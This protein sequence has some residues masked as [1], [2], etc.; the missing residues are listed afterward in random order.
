MGGT[1]M[2]APYHWQFTAAV[3][4]GSGQFVLADEINIAT[5][6]TGGALGDLDGDGDLDVFITQSANLPDVV[7]I[8]DGSGNFT[9]SG[10]ALGTTQSK[11]VGIAKLAR[12]LGAWLTSHKMVGV[13]G[14]RCA[15]H[16]NCSRPV[17]TARLRSAHPA[18]CVAATRDSPDGCRIS[19]GPRALRFSCGTGRRDRKRAR[20]IRLARGP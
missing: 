10:Q 3:G 12:W 5:A 14:G 17:R 15:R 7:F 11:A 16:R 8:N 6:G 1:P 19:V 13:T 4:R 18:W 2:S 20:C 9:D